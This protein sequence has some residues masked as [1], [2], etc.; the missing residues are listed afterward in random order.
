MLFNLDKFHLRGFDIFPHIPS[1]ELP[2]V[3]RLAVVIVNYGLFTSPRSFK[4][5]QVTFYVPCREVIFLSQLFYYFLQWHS[6]IT[7]Q[8][9]DGILMMLE[10]DRHIDKRE[11]AVG[12]VWRGMISTRLNIVPS[13]TLNW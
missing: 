3:R 12:Q 10:V 9:L 2:L 13:S 11:A 5:S 7:K 8:L 1:F 6:L 4:M